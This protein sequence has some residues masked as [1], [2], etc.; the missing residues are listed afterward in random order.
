LLTFIDFGSRDEDGMAKGELTHITGTF[1]IEAPASFLNG[2]GIEQGEY[3]NVTSPKHFRD[4][5]GDIPYVSAQAW[6]RWL[7]NTIIQETGWPPSELRAVSW[8]KKGNVN[9]IASELNPVEFAEDDLFGYMMAKSNKKQGGEEDEGED[10]DSDALEKTKGKVKSVMRP[11]P[12]SSSLLFSIGRMRGL[13]KDEGFVHLKE[14]TPLPYS[15]RFYSAHLQGIFSLEYARLGV[16][17]NVGDRIELDEQKVAQ[18]IAANKISV[19]HDLGKRGVVYQLTDMTTRKVRAQ[20]LLNA[21]ARLRGG[22]KQAQFAT[23]VAPKLLV[24]AG[25]SCGNPIFNQIFKLKEGDSSPLINIPK[26]QEIVKD[27]HE[28]IVTPVYLGIRTG[29]LQNES[30]VRALDESRVEDVQFLVR[31]PISVAEEIGNLLT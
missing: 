25:L 8:T 23:D 27:Y 5:V 26:L 3:E 14:G 29:Y 21:L 7:R 31:T 17:S 28:R 10:D 13:P 22:A 11:S 12:F 6:R 4:G 20:A 1:L 15:T 9:Q 2:S 18:M 30:D 16:F 19:R 24:M